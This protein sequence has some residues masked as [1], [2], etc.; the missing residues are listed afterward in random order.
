MTEPIVGDL[1]TEGEP[2]HFVRPAGQDAHS[3]IVYLHWF[4]E[5]PNANRDQFLD[6]AKTMATRG[7][8]AV[9]PQLSFPWKVPPTGADH[10]ASQIEA[11][12]T[13]LEDLTTEALAA[14]GAP[15]VVLVGHDFGAMHGM[16]LAQKVEPACVVSIAATPR[17][18]DWFLTFWPIEDDRFDYM[19]TLDPL[20]PVR[21]AVDLDMPTLYQFARND[22]YISPMQ[23]QQLARATP[24]PSRLEAYDADHS[25]LHPKCREDRINFILEALGLE[26]SGSS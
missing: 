22:F 10:D 23:G 16:L 19:R 24:E 25:M 9:L 4:D 14:S 3:L 13:R 20:D 12:V 1:Q 2:A 15:K 5:A 26:V 11:E 6:E 18:A 8:A 21:A 7:F 17:W